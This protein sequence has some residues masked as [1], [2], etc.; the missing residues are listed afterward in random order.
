MRDAPSHILDRIR[1]SGASA[2]A[3][4]GPTAVGKTAVSIHIAR[5]VK[6]EI[7]SVDSRQIY[8]EMTVGTAKPDSDEM[9]AVP[10]HL[11]D[12]RS[13]ANPITAAEYADLVDE[14]IRDIRARG[15]RV[16]L[17]GGSTLYLHATLYGLDNMPPSNPAIRAA[18]T[19]QLTQSGLDPL[20]AE[21]TARDPVAA[22]ETDLQNPRRVLRALEV[23]RTTGLRY[24]SFKTG[25]GQSKLRGGFGPVVVLNCGRDELYERIDRRVDQMIERGLVDEVRRILDSGYSPSLSSL[26]TIGYREMVSHLRDGAN[27]GV[28]VTRIKQNTRRYAK[29]QL[30]WLRRY[31]AFEWVDLSVDS[32][33]R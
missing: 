27:L 26:Q 5:A 15:L 9:A 1:T 18:L 22:A 13:V 8:R 12:E 11:V 4:V 20:V 31:P 32:G 17:V 6:A 25:S 2:A 7:V 16:I 30:T 3:I 29:R 28:C 21:L 24:S 19:D 33:R 10:H 23:I 14:R